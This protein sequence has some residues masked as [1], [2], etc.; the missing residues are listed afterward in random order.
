V[1]IE[2][3]LAR[4]RMLADLD[5]YDEADPLLAQ[6]L[7][8]EPDNEDGLSLFSR[9]LVARRRFQEAEAATERLLRAHPDSARGLLGMARI[10][11]LL[12]REPEGIPFARRAVELYPDNVSCLETLADVLRQVTHGS[13]EALELTRRA[14]E[15]DPEYVA[16]LRLAGEIHL[17]LAQYV[18][19]E[20]WLLRALAVAPEDPWT[21]LQLGLAHAGLGRFDES[22]EQ[23]TA[24]LRLRATPGMIGQV[25]EY[26]E[27]RAVPGHLAEVYRMALAA[28]GRPDVSCP[29]A[30]GDDPKLLAAQGKLAWKMY[31]RDADDDGHRRAG[32]LAA[33]V[34]A[35]DP[36][37]PDARYVHARVLCDNNRDAEALPIARQLQAEGYPSAHMALTTALSGTRDY[38]GALA[39]IREQLA[40]NPASL[41]YLRAEAQAL[42]SLKRYDEA[43]RSARRAAELSPYAPEVQLQL[44]LCAREAGELAL[45]ERALRT[46]VAE[47]PGEGYPAAELALLL[48]STERWPEAETLIGTLTAD[49]PDVSRLVHPCLQLASC[50]LTQV[51]SLWE[52]LEPDHPD[53]DGLAECAHWLELLLKVYTVGVTGHPE[54]VSTTFRTLPRL[55]DLLQEVAAPPDSDFAEVVRGLS[56]LLEGHRWALA[57]PSGS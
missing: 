15:I 11:C 56:A 44:G 36:R 27:S 53:P 17:S 4:A 49:L 14:L 38:A 30:A 26:I 9:G 12:R 35:A 48:A 54:V 18:E 55:V 43:L 5:R 40:V 2:D 19:A 57:S 13:A 21:V 8:Q 34:L 46:A 7:A 24:A 45:A 52:V 51:A 41:I 31:S 33:A 23:V 32:E 6:A 1:A 28:L 29:G 10:K 39:V 22:R 25:I 42:R 3:V 50:T 47:A 37:N 20:H 16:A